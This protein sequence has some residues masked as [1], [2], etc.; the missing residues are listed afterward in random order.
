MGYAF[1]G[2]FSETEHSVCV[3][4]MCF[5]SSRGSC[6]VVAMGTARILQARFLRCAGQY[7]IGI[8]MITVHQHYLGRRTHLLLDAECSPSRY[9]IWAWYSDTSKCVEQL[10]HAGT[11]PKRAF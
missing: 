10:T 4:E 9:M 11:L 3:R 2:I 7:V 8:A 1:L 6:I 5:S